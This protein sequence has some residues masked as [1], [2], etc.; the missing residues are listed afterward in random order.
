MDGSDGTE[1][2][3]V[4]QVGVP[5]G[6]G[7]LVGDHNTQHNMF[8]QTIIETQ[9]V[10]TQV[11]QLPPAP[12]LGQVVAGNVPQE[13]PAFQQRTDLL[14]VLRASPRVPLV[15]V[16]T[17]MRGAGKTQAAAAYARTC[18]G[19][20]WRLVAWVN[21]GDMAKVLDGL[22]VVAERLRIGAADSSLEALGDLI[23]DRLA[24]DGERCL[25]VFDSVTDLA[26]LR[27]FLPAAGK[28]HRPE[29]PL[30]ITG[31]GVS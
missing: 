10:G 21:A 6:Q 30:P 18:I 5:A 19:D 28:S 27:R 15:H 16:L 22:A 8:G 11:V 4:T 2:P 7:V 23:R 14:G 20:G 3:S 25:V 24:A 13:P 17:G 9:Y 1:Q 12:P 29:R 31:C 26:G